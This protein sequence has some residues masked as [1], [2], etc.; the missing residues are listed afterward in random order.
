[1]WNANQASTRKITRVNHKKRTSIQCCF[2]QSNRPAV[3][4]D[5]HDGA[6][7][8]N[9]DQLLVPAQQNAHL[10][11]TTTLTQVARLDLREPCV[12]GGDRLLG[13]LGTVARSRR[14]HTLVPSSNVSLDS[15]CL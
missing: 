6:S 2:I 10:L 3:S 9:L 8:S 11:T 5:T 1:M 14:R 13:R 4:H 15:Q 12:L 7:T